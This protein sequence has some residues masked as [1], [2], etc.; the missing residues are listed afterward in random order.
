MKIHKNILDI[1]IDVAKKSDVTRGKVG[2]VCFTNTKNVIAFAH[3]KIVYGKTHKR[4]FTVH[5]EVSLLAKLVRLRASSRFGLKNL[6]ILV[7]RYKPETDGLAI[8]KPCANC[9]H[10][11]KLA[12][13]R[14][15]YTDA[16]GDIMPLTFRRK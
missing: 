14:V 6:N 13:V 3:N 11:L 16:N 1:A 7:V 8:A 10:Y 2:A 5:A 12:G 9:Q 15:F 4:I